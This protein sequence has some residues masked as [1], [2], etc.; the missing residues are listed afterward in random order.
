MDRE[1]LLEVFGWKIASEV[2]T[3][4]YRILKL[5]KEQIFTKAFEIVNKLCIYELLLEIGEQMEEAQLQYCLQI[6]SLIDFLYA[7]WLKVSDSKNDE[8]DAVIKSVLK[9]V[10]VE[11]A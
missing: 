5:S 10:K 4:K 1:S 6:P 8:L 7:E 2:K 3:M 9:L 11:A